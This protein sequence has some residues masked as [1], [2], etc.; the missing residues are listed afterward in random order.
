MRVLSAGKR[1]CDEMDKEDMIRLLERRG[2]SKRVL[3]AMKKVPRHLFVPPDVRK[4]AYEDRPLPIGEGQ[5]ISAP[6]MVAMMCEYLDLQ[7]GHK[8]LEIGG[9]CG[10]HAA[11]MAE[12]VGKEGKVITVERIESLADRAKQNLK[13]TGYDDV[14]EVVVG[15][16]TLGYPPEAPYDRISVACAAPSVP[17]PLKEQLKIKGKM[18]IPVG[19]HSQI[20]YLVKKKGEDGFD[21]EKLCEVVFVPLIG[22]HGFHM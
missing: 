5:T 6:H 10:Y 4:F 19:S 15:D 9:G 14:V 17:P 8:V 22:K 7:K 20:L 16:G 3:E 13:L 2:I 12:L 18:V 1:G 21:M 11:V